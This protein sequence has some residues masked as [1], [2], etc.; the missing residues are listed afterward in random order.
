MF[1]AIPTWVQEAVPGVTNLW[2]PDAYHHKGTWYLYYS[3]ST[4]GSNRSV[5]GL[6]T[7]PALD[8]DHPD[9]EWVDRGQVWASTEEDDYNAI[10][11]GVVEDADGTPWLAFGSFWSGIRM[12]RLRWPSGQAS[13]GVSTPLRLAD[14]QVP[15]NAIEAPY[16]VRH[17]DWYYLFCS[18]D[19]CC[20]GTDSTYKITVGRSRNVTGPYVDRLGTPLLHGG[21]TVILSER[22]PMVGPGGQSISRGWLAH[23]YYDA[24]AEG[25]PR[26]SIRAIDWSRGWPRVSTAAPAPVPAR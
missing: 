13:P 22:G 24:R 26:L 6:A 18:I 21:G 20:Q 25:A 4:F 17:G 8:P 15:P 3:G 5:I 11:P 23:H 19:E 16:I 10:D 9:H 14:R 2:A 12:V 1:D 7:T